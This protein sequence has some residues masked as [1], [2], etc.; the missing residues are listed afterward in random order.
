M[1]F[2][3]MTFD[4]ILT[5][6]QQDTG[7]GIKKKNRHLTGDFCTQCWC[8]TTISL[9]VKVTVLKNPIETFFHTKKLN[10]C[11]IKKIRHFL[12]KI[13]LKQYRYRKNRYRYRLDIGIFYV[14]DAPD[15]LDAP[16]QDQQGG[17]DVSSLLLPVV[18]KREVK[19]SSAADP[20]TVLITI[21][22]CTADG[23][24]LE[25]GSVKIRKK[26]QA[27]TIKFL[28]IFWN[29]DCR[30]LLLKPYNWKPL[31]QG[32]KKANLDA[33]PGFKPYDQC[34]SAT[35]KK[36]MKDQGSIFYANNDIPPPLSEIIFF[37]LFCNISCLGKFHYLSLWNIIL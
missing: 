1:D 34:G 14:N 29:C 16:A 26:L 30:N 32:T 7:T 12:R 27:N 13:D 31:D 15:G 25:S 35:K 20:Y 17:V 24:S 4:R 23:R 2:S 18:G 9:I 11:L 33:R 28:F 36:I 6:I 19:I 8:D 37:P 21:Q 10:E 22:I 3:G 5:F